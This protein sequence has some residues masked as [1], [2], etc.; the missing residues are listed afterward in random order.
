MD[1][2]QIAIMI[3]KFSK[4]IVIS[5]SLWGIGTS[6]LSANTPMHILVMG[7][8]LLASHSATG[9]A[10]SDSIAK[11]LSATVTDKSVMAARIIYKLPITGSMGMS[12]PKQYR[13]GDWDWVVVNG[14]GNDLVFGCGCNRCGR[15]MNKLV[16]ETGQRGGIPKLIAS[17]RATGARV[18]YVGYL[19]SPGV[20]SPIEN[21]KDEGDELERRIG[22]LAASDQGV[23][24]VSLADLVP[25]GDRSYHAVDMVH[26]SLKAS[27]EIG[28][29][30]AD[31]IRKNP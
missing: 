20:D 2:I 23:F 31:V 19:R 11:S 1:I 21:C 13:K 3:K 29:R 26:P 27:R 16:G 4:A 30:I 14:G 17:L 25:F 10:V 22:E 15:K 6:A 12:I 28:V 18:I 7:D 9:R 8:S 5:A 24:L